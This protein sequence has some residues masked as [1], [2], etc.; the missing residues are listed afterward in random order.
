MCAIVYYTKQI[1]G[2]LYPKAARFG[3]YAFAQ[4]VS[5]VRGKVVTRY[6]GIVK[7]P[8][9]AAVVENGGEAD[10]TDAIEK[11]EG[12]NHGNDTREP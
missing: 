8:K 2:R 7:V 6:V 9:D 11:D 5:R 10:E 12:E 4:E 3:S 1:K